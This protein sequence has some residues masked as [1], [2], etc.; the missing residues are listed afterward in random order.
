[1]TAML[2]RLE[3]DDYGNVA[4]GEADREKDTGIVRTP[5]G[6]ACGLHDPAARYFQMDVVA[7]N[8]SEWRARCDDPG[9]CPSDGWMLS[10]KGV[11][12]RPGERG[13]DGIHVKALDLIGYC[14]VIALSDGT[15]LN[16]NLLP[17]LELFESERRGVHPAQCGMFAD[18][19]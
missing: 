12:G 19:P 18:G 1:M 13:R 2:H 17:A 8:G 9:A 4:G 11:R 5:G 6:R 10:A 14:I 3:L 16:V 15:T 7:F